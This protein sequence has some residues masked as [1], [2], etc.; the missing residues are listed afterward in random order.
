M[1]GA[2]EVNV[3][4]SFV[5]MVVADILQSGK[6]GGTEE[7]SKQILVVFRNSPVTICAFLLP[8]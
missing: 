6:S 1:L 4:V 5:A 3:F 7:C 2:Q 8:L